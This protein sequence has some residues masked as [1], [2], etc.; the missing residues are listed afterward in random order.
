MC[1]TSHNVELVGKLQVSGRF[2]DVRRSQ[3]ADVATKGDYAYLSSYQTLD[4]RPGA[5]QGSCERGGVFIVD[6]SNPAVP[7]EVGF[8]K[9]PAGSFPGEGEQVIALDTPAFKG[10]VLSVNQEYCTAAG[11]GNS[12]TEATRRGGISLYDV[13]DPLHPVP[14]AENFGDVDLAQNNDFDPS[15][16]KLSPEHEYHSVFSWQDGSRA[17]AVA[18]DNF[19]LSVDN[20]V[21]IFEITDPRAPRLLHEFNVRDEL[22]DSSALGE[23]PFLHDMIVKEIDATKLDVAPPLVIVGGYPGERER[24]HPA[25][26]IERTDAEDVF[27]GGWHGHDEPGF[28]NASDVVVLPSVR[29]QFGEVLVEGMA[30]GLPAI[31]VDAHGPRGD[32]RTRARRAGWWS[33]TTS[34][35]GRRRAPAVAARSR[36]GGRDL[37]AG[38]TAERRRR[39]QD[40]R[41]PALAPPAPGDRWRRGGGRRRRAAAA[42]A[43]SR[44]SRDVARSPT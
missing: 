34:R 23:D 31:A 37:D 28:L 19:D 16:G 44:D 7:R 2:G 36:R 35:G 15:I 18:T 30:C 26:T 43:G 32:R 42:A 39:G 11:A 41:A 20:D 12:G 38:G 25:D 33:P 1:S 3:I 17:F 9:S 27:L 10:D 24:E 6:I 29:E 4:A 5:D 13:T 40:R 14:L 21:D 22:A 8:I